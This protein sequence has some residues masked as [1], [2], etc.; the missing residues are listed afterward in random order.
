MKE[1]QREMDDILRKLYDATSIDENTLIILMG[2]HGMNEVGNHGGSSAGETNAGLVFISPKF[3]RLNLGLVSPLETSLNYSYYRKIQQIDLIPTIAALL[4]FPIPK[5]SLG[6]FIKEILGLWDPSQ[7]LK[8][9]LE[10]EEQIRKL[11][12]GKYNLDYKEDNISDQEDELY[13]NWK[14]AT[15][16][17]SIEGIFTFLHAAQT[18]LA[19]SAT[20]YDMDSIWYGI[21][22]LAAALVISLVF[23][24]RYFV[25][26]TL[27]D[28]VISWGFLGFVVLY[29]THF[30]ASSFIEEE[31]Q[32]WWFILTIY[33]SA[34]F[35]F[36]LCRSTGSFLIVIS[37]IRIIRAFSNTGQKFKTPFTLSA[38]FL[39]NPSVLWISNIAT[40]SLLSILMFCQGGFVNTFSLANFSFSQRNPN[41]VGPLLSF[42]ATFV[43]ASLSFLFKLCQYAID[44]NEIPSWLTLH[45]KWTVESFGVDPDTS[46][47]LEVLRVLVQMSRLFVYSELL[48]VALR[49]IVGKYRKITVGMYT[50]ICNIITVFLVHQTRAEQIPVFLVFLVIRFLFAKIIHDNEKRFTSNMDQFILIVSTFT[51]ALQQVSFFSVGNTNLLATVDL[52]NAYNGISSYNVYV[53]GVLTF[54]SNFA[55]PIFWSLTSFGWLLE[56]RILTF[57]ANNTTNLSQNRSLALRVHKTKFLVTLTF[58]AASAVFL[59]GSCINLRYHLFIWTVF[60]PKLLF[61]GAWSLL[62]NGLVDFIFLGI[63]LSI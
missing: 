59:V 19:T 6:V 25:F 21:I 3:K 33:L 2:D 26:Q 9:L 52:S 12:E 44:G 55:G 13:S 47:K 18:K 4:D 27:V 37:C 43:T 36:N 39:D 57:K 5:N 42:I 11:V 61:F 50:D 63:Q 34:L 8:I 38:F 56:H 20:N 15:K 54:I 58:Y 45:M 30:F 31:H 7:Q 40:Y 46:T 1:K 48:L 35:Y 22:L 28:K 29:S 53:V 24:I 51:L 16:L 14:I 32:L 41:D 60:S 17:T 10:N 49:I 62:I 23:F